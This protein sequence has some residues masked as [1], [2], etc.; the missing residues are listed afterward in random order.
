MT[1]PASSAAVETADPAGSVVGLAAAESVHPASARRTVAVICVMLAYQG[2]T[3]S[4]NGIASP[5]I[6]KSFALGQSGIAALFACISFSAIGALILSRL[7]DR[8]GR[9][10][11][12]LACMGATPVCA[13]GAAL[14]FRIPA[15]VAFEILIYAF[16]GATQAGAVVMLAEALPIAQ[17]ARGQ[18]FGGLA[19]GLGGGLCLTLMPLLDRGGYSWR[20]LLAVSATGLL[21]FPYV[22]RVVPESQRWERAAEAGTTRASRFID[23]FGLRYRRRAVPILVC[24]LLSTIAFNAATSWGYYHAVTVVG[25]SAAGASLMMLIGGGV[26]MLGFPLGAAAAERFGRVPTVV[27]C[28]IVA[29]AGTLFFYWGPPAGSTSAGLWLGV[30]FCWFMATINAATVGGNAAATELFPTALRGT[31]IGWFTLIIA[32]GSVASQAAIA[33]LAGPLGG[34]SIV[35]GYLGLLAVPS[36]IVFGLFIEETRGLSLEVAAKE[37]GEPTL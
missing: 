37:V 5:W 34:L 30:G 33:A 19:M 15:F 23:V 9:R 16:I 17:R 2:Y 28:C 7:S 12:L 31:M 26:S 10:R 20:W 24:S 32:I 36:A 22:L 11:I 25:L 14:S 21:A 6:A 1:D 4:I 27:S 3:M 35:V 29:T 13:L 18:S 8:I